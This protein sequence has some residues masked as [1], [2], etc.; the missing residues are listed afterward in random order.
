MNVYPVRMEETSGTISIGFKSEKK[1]EGNKTKVDD[2]E[3]P[4]QEK[5]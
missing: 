4:E 1:D 3:P 2:N 5:V